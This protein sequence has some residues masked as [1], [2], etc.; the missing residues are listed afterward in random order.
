[1][2]APFIRTLTMTLST[3]STT[4]GQRGLLYALR[5]FTGEGLRMP[6]CVTGEATFLIEYI[7]LVAFFVA[8]GVLL[9]VLLPCTRLILASTGKKVCFLFC[10]VKVW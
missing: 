10:V 9:L 2:R 3:T 8:F 1:M 4:T 5:I 6:G 7:S